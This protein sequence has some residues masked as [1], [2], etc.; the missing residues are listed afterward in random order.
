MARFPLFYSQTIIVLV[1]VPSIKDFL[2]FNFIVAKAVTQ[3]WLSILLFF[4]DNST[5]FYFSFHLNLSTRCH[6]LFFFL[7]IKPR[8]VTQSTSSVILLKE[9][10]KQI[11]H[12]RKVVIKR[13]IMFI[14]NFASIMG[15]CLPFYRYVILYFCIINVF[16]CKIRFQKVNARRK[17]CLCVNQLCQT[18]NTPGH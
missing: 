13:I 3:K 6:N 16:R 7:R 4:H 2:F 5:I 9:K 12:D 8:R 18:G 17:N 11:S 10:K 14:H 15:T 1:H